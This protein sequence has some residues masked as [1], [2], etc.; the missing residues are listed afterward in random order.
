M[1]SV[2]HEECCHKLLKMKI[3]S[4]NMLIDMIIDCCALEK[5]FLKF[6][7]LLIEQF[8]RLNS[9][10]Y[11]PIV[12]LHFKQLYLTIHRYE[13]G[14]IRNLSLLYA[15]LLS[16][17]CIS[18][19]ILHENVVLT[20][21]DTTAPSRIFIKF[22]FQELSRLLT[23]HELNQRL[24]AFKAEI[25]D[26]PFAINFFTSIDLGQ[27]TDDLR[28]KLMKQMNQKKPKKKPK[29]QTTVVQVTA[30]AV[31][32]TMTTAV[33]VTTVTAVRVTATVT[34]AVRVTQAV[35]AILPMDLP[36]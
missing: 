34:A 22:L 26:L 20:Q 23:V 1:N 24:T 29:K 11:Q 31:Q 8:L 5:T 16:K 13:T 21:Q 7:G 9:D 10:L 18:W 4:K 17:Q 28:L 12:E 35:R 15:Y 27:L 3:S 14:K 33:R 25:I 30:T 6:Y 36:L 32:V 19:H 2:S